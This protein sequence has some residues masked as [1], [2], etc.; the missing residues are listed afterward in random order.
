MILVMKT[1]SGKGLHTQTNRHVRWFH[2]FS[3]SFIIFSD[4]LLNGIHLPEKK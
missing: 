4:L 3:F 1:P 2:S